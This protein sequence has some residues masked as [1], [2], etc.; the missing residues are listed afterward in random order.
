MNPAVRPV[1]VGSVVPRTETVIV[2]NI[3]VEDAIAGL[4]ALN[5]AESVCPAS[6]MEVVV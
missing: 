4:L 3:P 1:L 5:S 2:Q 6:A